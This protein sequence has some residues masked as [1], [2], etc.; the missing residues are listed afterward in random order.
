MKGYERNVIE[1]ALAAKGLNHRKLAEQI[2]RSNTSVNKAIK[3]TS[4]I[5]SEKLETDIVT[6]LQPEL[7]VIDRALQAG[8]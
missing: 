4:T 7:D 6:A 5:R 3:G 1:A 2:G 8:A